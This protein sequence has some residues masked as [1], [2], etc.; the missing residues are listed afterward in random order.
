MD[1]AATG[2]DALKAMTA[3]ETSIVVMHDGTD[4]HPNGVRFT[5]ALRNS[6]SRIPNADVT[7]V[8]IVYDGEVT[9]KILQD[10]ANAGA[11]YLLRMPVSAQSLMK[12]MHFAI[13]Q[14]DA[15]R[16]RALKVEVN[17]RIL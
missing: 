2:A 14:P 4:S 17:R 6:L 3:S 1:Q 10:V 16:E 12:A 13:T 7:P 11:N 8:V 5:R 15:F 9:L